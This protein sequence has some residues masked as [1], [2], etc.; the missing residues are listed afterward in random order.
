[1][2]PTQSLRIDS[3][4]VVLRT[5][6]HRATDKHGPMASPHEGYSVILEEL[7]ELWEHVKH[8]TG[9]SEAALKEAMQIAAMGLRYILDMEAKT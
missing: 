2:T 4:C 3:L 9:K 8:D 1:M 7:D 5:E 6:L